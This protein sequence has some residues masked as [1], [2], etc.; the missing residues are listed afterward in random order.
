MVPLSFASGL[1]FALGLCLSGMVR[2]S[3]VLGFLNLGGAWDP[4]LAFVMVGA[5][6]VFAAAWR[7]TRR[8]SAPALGGRFPAAPPRG[9]D[10]R[11][12]GGA[13]VFGLGWGLGG[14]CPGPAIVGLVASRGAVVFVVA[15][16]AGM[17]ACDLAG[18][19]TAEDG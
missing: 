18:R 5:L 3:K 9:V 17:L 13:A 12:L 1:V 14:F 10:L 19:R 11:L 4:S 6:A 16:L 2:P 8:R 15:M 7:W